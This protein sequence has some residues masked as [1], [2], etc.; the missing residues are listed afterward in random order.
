MRDVAPPET[1]WSIHYGSE[2]IRFAVR[3]QPERRKGSIAIHVEPEG[4]VLVD[5]PIDASRAAILAS[6]RKRA[7]WVHGHIADFLR[8]HAH[9]LPREYVSGES[10]MYLGRRYRLK[11][12]PTDAASA[13]VKLSGGHLE[14]RMAG[15]MP[16]SVRDALERWYRARARMIFA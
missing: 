12:I 11:V 2:I 15:S 14:V 3:G 16:E 13:G 8:R 7:K 5:A 10:I 9:V 4:I 1:S 6:V